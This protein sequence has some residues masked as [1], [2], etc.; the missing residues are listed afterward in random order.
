MK[1]QGLTM[2]EVM[3]AMVV[4]GIALAFFANLTSTNLRQSTV[5]GA[6]TQSGQLLNYFGRRVVGGDAMVL[7]A[8]GE[9]L[10]WAYGELTGAFPDLRNEG[11][12][13][14]PDRYSVRIVSNGSVSL[15]AANMR[16]YDI[17][18]CQ[19]G[20]E[21]TCVTGTTLGPPPAPGGGAGGGFGVN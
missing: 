18:V 3:V 11:S 6:R 14:N 17:T 7:P 15:A 1:Q 9:S 20:Q 16:R 10:S 2:L 13:A 8:A 21:G 5:S 19:Q 4:I 12:F